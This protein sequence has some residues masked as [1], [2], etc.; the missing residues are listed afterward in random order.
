MWRE[1]GEGDSHH[2]SGPDH[3]VGGDVLLRAGDAVH[4]LRLSGFVFISLHCI[5]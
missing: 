1:R 2:D 5:V 3:P 4:V